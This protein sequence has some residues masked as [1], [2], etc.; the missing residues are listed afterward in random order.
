MELEKMTLHRWK[1][2]LCLK[3]GSVNSASSMLDIVW[4]TRRTPLLGP[5][6]QQTMS[7]F[8]VQLFVLCS[9]TCYCKCRM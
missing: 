7:L 6:R 4:D 3:S 1:L 9:Y 2:I 5:Q 8:P